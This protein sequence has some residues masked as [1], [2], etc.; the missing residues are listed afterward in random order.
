MMI[1]KQSIM[2]SVWTIDQFDGRMIRLKSGQNLLVLQAQP[3]GAYD[4]EEYEDDNGDRHRLMWDGD[5][6]RLIVTKYSED[7]TINIEITQRNN[8]FPIALMVDQPMA[9]W[10]DFKRRADEQ[11]GQEVAEP[12]DPT[13]GRRRKTR[14]TKKSRR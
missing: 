13:A 10:E 12:E 5:V 8:G 6:A 9:L 1:S 4:F 3:G 11:Q 7:G 2:A 14:R